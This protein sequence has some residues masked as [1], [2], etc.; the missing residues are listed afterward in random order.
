MEAAL[1]GGLLMGVAA[2][3]AL[4]LGIDVGSLD[5]TL[6]LGFPGSVSS[7]LQ[8][9]GRAGRRE[10]PSAS[11]Y[12]AF[13]GPTDQFFFR[14]PEQ[15]FERPVEKAQIDAQNEQ[16]MGQHLACAALELPLLLD[17]DQA[18]FGPRL[19]AIAAELRSAGLLSRHPHMPPGVNA[20]LYTGMRD[21]PAAAFS[22]RAIDPERYQIVN[23]AA[24]GAVIEE[25]EESKA[26]FEVYDG[27]VYLY[28][29][30]RCT[31]LA[32]CAGCAVAHTLLQVACYA[33]HCW[34]PA[35]LQVRTAWAWRETPLLVVAMQTQIFSCNE[36]RVAQ[37]A[38]R[39]VIG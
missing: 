3:N 11:I 29:A 6:H 7:L 38:L 10:Q 25:I 37:W 26:F 16:L 15:L 35:P 33:A 32:G 24:D 13:D 4:E 19:P 39:C 18:Y 17:A 30:R 28:Q 23:E 2:T 34:A 31:V 5:V 8:Q 12:V 27:A 22:L 9:A 20:L 1:F 36:L 14:H 21:N